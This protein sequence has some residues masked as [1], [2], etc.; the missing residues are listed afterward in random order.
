MVPLPV[1]NVPFSRVAMDL[2]GSL[3][4]SRLGNRY[5]LVLCDYATR[6]PEAV[7]LR[8]IDA[9]TIAEELIQIFARVGLPQEILIDQGANFQ[10][11]LLQEIH[12]PLRVR[13]IR[14][15]PYHPQTDGLVEKFNQTLKSMLRKCAREGG[16]DWDKMVPFLLFAYREVPQEST[17]FSPFELLYGRDVRG[18]LDVMR[19]TWVSNKRAS[20][21]ILSYVL[22]MRD[23]MATM[24]DHVQENLKA[25]GLRQKK[26]YD[27][28]ARDRTFQVGDQVLVLLPSSTSKLMAQWQ[29][30]YRVLNRVGE[31][32]YLID[33][34]D[35]K[36]KK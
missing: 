10:S 1:V 8:N 31:V 6:Y 28:N 18:P 23:R 25:A 16:K 12:H 17:G 14:T 2:V 32:N 21:D 3:P 29:G 30:P 33:M 15:S 22:L 7:P 11:Q 19:E 27:R 34:P 9:E 26:W 20:Q 13:A 24:N 5:V 35:H 4:R 36:K